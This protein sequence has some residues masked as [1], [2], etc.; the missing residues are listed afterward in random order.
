MKRWDTNFIT[1][2]EIDC[3]YGIK[4]ALSALKTVDLGF[5]NT[6]KRYCVTRNEPERKEKCVFQRHT[7]EQEPLIS[8]PRIKSCLLNV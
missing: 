7:Q 3:N 4:A 6:T 1:Y 5:N 8:R 2:T